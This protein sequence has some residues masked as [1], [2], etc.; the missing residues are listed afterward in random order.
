M[1]L[2]VTKFIYITPTQYSTASSTD[3]DLYRYSLHNFHTCPEAIRLLWVIYI[4]YLDLFTS[5]CES[6]N[7]EWRT[8]FWVYRK[9]DGTDGTVDVARR[10][11]ESK[12]MKRLL[13]LIHNFT[14]NFKCLGA[15]K[16]IVF[17]IYSKYCARPLSH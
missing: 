7:V 10:R 6:V 15:F 3:E 5:A 13:L 12:Y 4:E 8:Y 9:R 17:N 14:L 1:L 16:N 2:C 11:S